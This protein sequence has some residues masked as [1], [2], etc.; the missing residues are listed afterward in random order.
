MMIR[1]REDDASKKSRD[2]VKEIEAYCAAAHFFLSLCMAVSCSVIH[3]IGERTYGA[4][5]CASLE[6]AGA[7]GDATL[8][9]AGH[10]G[11]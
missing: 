7:S 1:A 11:M 3:L 9:A 6:A 8:D 5:Q 4:M 2:T 10:A